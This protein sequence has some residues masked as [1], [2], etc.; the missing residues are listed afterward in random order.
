MPNGCARALSQE[1]TALARQRLAAGKNAWRAIKMA[2]G[3]ALARRDPVDLKDGFSRLEKS[4]ALSPE[5]VPAAQ[6]GAVALLRGAA[7]VGSDAAPE[8]TG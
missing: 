3:E 6:R 1:Y 5:R 4:A 8:S 2:A 7:G